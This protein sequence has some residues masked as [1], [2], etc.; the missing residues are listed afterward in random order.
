MKDKSGEA[1]DVGKRL[2][3]IVDYV[4]DCRIRVTKGEIMDLQGLDKNVISLCD[5]IAALP[6]EE[7]RALEGQMSGLIDSLEELARAMKEQQDKLGL[8]EGR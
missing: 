6:E 7:G 3:T 8:T 1:A 5:A 4:R 2:R